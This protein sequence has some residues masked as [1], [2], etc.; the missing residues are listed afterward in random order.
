MIDKDLTLFNGGGLE[1]LVKPSGVK[2][3][4]YRW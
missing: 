3:W 4:R 2:I 1:L